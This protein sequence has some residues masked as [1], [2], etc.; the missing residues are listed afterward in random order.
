MWPSGQRTRPPCAVERDALSGR[1]SRHGRAR[2]PTAL[3]RYKSL[4]AGVQG[5]LNLCP[6]I[7]NERTIKPFRNVLPVTQP[8]VTETL[9]T[10]TTL[11][12]RYPLAASRL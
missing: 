1:C 8:T 9:F 10:K 4:G 3:D 6:Q 12:I 11:G 7:T 2:P 5:R